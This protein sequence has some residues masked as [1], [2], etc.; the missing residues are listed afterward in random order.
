MTPEEA[1]KASTNYLKNLAAMKNGYVAV[2]LPVSKVADKTYGSGQSVIDAGAAHEF[3]TN[4][5]PE[6]SFLRAP[7]TLKKSEINRL[8]A[9]QVESV[10]SGAID[11]NQALNLIG[12]AARNISVKAFE[13]AGYGTWPDIKEATKAAKKSSGI[14]IDTGELRGAITWEVRSE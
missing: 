11:A 14:L 3:G 4:D 6:R 9:K 8:I 10:G 1:L 12:I 13:T 7:F 2:G 5:L